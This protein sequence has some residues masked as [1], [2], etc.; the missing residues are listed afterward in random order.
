MVARNVVQTIVLLVVLGGCRGVTPDVPATSVSLTPTPTQPLPFATMAS[1]ES[2]TVV[3]DVISVEVSGDPNAYRFAVEIRSPDLGCDQYADWWEVVLADGTLLYRRILAHSHV[4][5][6]PFV[7]S[8]GPVEIGPDTVVLVRAHMHPQG[9]GGIALKG[10]AVTG[11]VEA[12]V[13]A[14]FAADVE[15]APPQPDGCAF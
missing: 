15:T 7:R 14:D 1:A 9:Y 12:N 2:P 8:G 4:D 10:T 5:E 6:Q 3:A 13:G 11:F